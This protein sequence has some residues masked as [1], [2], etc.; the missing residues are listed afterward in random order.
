MG[1]FSNI[2]KLFPKVKSNNYTVV[3]PHE[4][5]K[6]YCLERMLISLLAENRYL[7]KSD[8]FM[9]KHD[10]SEIDKHFQVIRNGGILPEYCHKYSL[11]QEKVILA[12]DTLG[13]METKVNRHNLDYIEKAK[14]QEKHYLDNILREVDPNIVLDDNQREVVLTQED[15]CLVIA[16]AGAGKTTTVAAK[17]KYLVDK[18]NVDPKQILVISFTNKAVEELQE[19]INK[20]LSIDCPITTF[21]SAGNAIIRKKVNQKLSIVDSSKLYYV[22]MDYFR[23]NLLHNERMVNNLILFFGSYFDAPYEGNDL[24]EFFNSVATARYET[25]KSDLNEYIQEI[26]DTRSKKQVTIA[27]EILRS[28]QEVEIANFLYLNGIDYQYEPI[29]PFNI[30]LARKPYTPDFII[31]QGDNVAYIEHFGITESGQ[32]NRFSQDEIESYKRAIKEKITLHGRHGT[33]LIYTFSGY[34]DQRSL[35]DHLKEQLEKNRFALNPRSQR[36]VVEKLVFS[37]QSRYIRKL[38]DLVC[39]FI[40]NFKTNA[41]QVEDFSRMSNSTKNVRAKLFLDICRGC[42]LEYQRYLSENDAV[43]FQDMINESARILREVKEMKQKLDFKYIIVD[44]Y[45]DIS[46]QRFDLT[47]ELSTV[48]D[49]KIIAVGDDWQS[50]YAFSGSDITLFT[51]FCEIMGYGKLLKIVNTYRNAQEVIDIA[52]NFIQK[53]SSQIQKELISPKS[54]KDPVIIYTYDSTKKTNQESSRSGFIYAIANAVEVAI[55]QIIKFNKEDSKGWNSNILLLGRFGFDGDNLARSGLFEYITRGSKIRSVKYPKLDITFM[56]AHSSKGLGYDNVIVIN[57]RNEKYGFPSKI[58]DDPVLSFV[59]KEDRSIEYAEERRL[60][61]VAMTRTKNRVFFIAPEQNPSEFLLEIKRDYK[62]VLLR[63]NWHENQY[64]QVYRKICPICG[65]PLQFRYKNSYGLRLYICTNEPELCGFLTNDLQGKKMS[66]QKC[67]KCSN[68]Y[69]VVKRSS[70]GKTQPFL[71]CTNYSRNRKG[72]NH[73]V[74]MQTYYSQYSLSEDMI[75]KA[76]SEIK[77]SDGYADKKQDNRLNPVKSDVNA[78]ISNP[79]ELEKTQ[80]KISLVTSSSNLEDADIEKSK[81]PS[82]INE[83]TSLEPIQFDG[84]YLMDIIGSILNCVKEISEKHFFGKSVLLN[85]LR[86][87]SNKKVLNYKLELTSEYGRLSC[88][89]REDIELIIDW[90]ISEAFLLQRN[91]RYPVLYL[92]VKGNHYQE[93]MTNKKLRYLAKMLK[94]Y[95]PNSNLSIKEKSKK[96]GTPLPISAGMRWTIE[97]DK[98]LL[99][100]IQTGLKASEIAKIHNRT[101]GA[102]K[103]RVER[104]NEKN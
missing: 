95:S 60:F 94:E 98:Q 85:V 52:G 19:K 59:I 92:T 64:R 50:I 97:E 14:V 40:S 58:E 36:E 45:Q 66:I 96:V 62:S 69:L 34:N 3:M 12:L 2:S 73:S 93:T 71:G 67:N 1:I 20:F 47:K 21:H 90:L 100:E 91:S 18:M 99:N 9:I 57:G 78:N 42:Y 70:D 61:Y 23:G 26:S 82:N 75:D 13:N 6:L 32:N 48:T 87:S 33:A 17:I 44:E 76:D 5:E 80:N 54:I 77:T 49:A 38:I 79:V 86:G 89:K 103:A 55:E 35:L 65:Y 25:L 29:Y 28:R 15:Y 53:N 10:Y 22:L 81:E 8:Y 63:G 30:Q 51:K 16:G 46:R 88:L 11:N 43:D 83:K 68:G 37:E 27:N 74:S 104:L 72:C 39:R 7:A 24:N 101:Y 56:T 41:Y 31:R 84:T 102:I 4:I